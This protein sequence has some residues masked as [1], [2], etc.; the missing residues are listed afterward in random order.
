MQVRP[1]AKTPAGMK[2]GPNK[3]AYTLTHDTR[4]VR[5][6]INQVNSPSAAVDPRG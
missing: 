4:V 5:A 6:T 1:I 2:I 3:S